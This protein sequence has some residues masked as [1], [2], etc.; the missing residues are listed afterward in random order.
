MKKDFFLYAPD[1][2]PYLYPDEN[3]ENYSPVNIL[4]PDY[5]IHPLF[6]KA[7]GLK[8]TLKPGETLF[9]PSGW[10]HT[11]YIHNFNLTY[12]VDHVNANN[13]NIYMDKNYLTSKI[14]RPKLAWIL[15]AYK[16][17]MGKVFNLKESFKN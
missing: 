15:K 8:V 2:T 10:W 12:A 7:K 17:S 6:K 1:Q 13:W 14:R 3:R 16:V 4:N 5:S 11:T 9:I